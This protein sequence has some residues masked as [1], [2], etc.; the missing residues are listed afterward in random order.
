MLVIT[1]KVDNDF[2]T[3]K[4]AYEDGFTIQ[5]WRPQ[6]H[7]WVDLKRPLWGEKTQYRVKPG[8][9]A[10]ASEHIVAAANRTSPRRFHL[11]MFLAGAACGLFAG[12]LLL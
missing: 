3:L 10:Q 12:A 11:L 1:H 2:K 4:R 7:K 9:L 6:E 8:A 5:A